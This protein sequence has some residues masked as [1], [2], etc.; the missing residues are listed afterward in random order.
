MIAIVA[1]EDRGRAASTHAEIEKNLLASRSADA[2]FSGSY[3]RTGILW[4]EFVN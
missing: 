4:Q 3:F 1:R 2:I